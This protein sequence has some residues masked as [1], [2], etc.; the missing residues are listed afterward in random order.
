M[1]STFF[2]FFFEKWILAD[3][4]NTKVGNHPIKKIICLVEHTPARFEE[5]KIV[6]LAGL[7]HVQLHY[8]ADQRERKKYSK[9]SLTWI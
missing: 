9:K 8:L 7:R 5:K 4:T 2:F 6:S 1:E 3:K